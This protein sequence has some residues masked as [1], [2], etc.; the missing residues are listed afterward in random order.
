MKIG[1]FVAFGGQRSIQLRDDEGRK[2]LQKYVDNENTARMREQVAFINDVLAKGK[3][4]LEITRDE[5]ETL[6][7]WMHQRS[8]ERNE[9]DG[10]LRLQDVSL[11]RVFN[12]T[13][14]AT[15][16]RFYGG[17]WQ[18]IPSEYRTRIRINEK[19][20]VELDFGTLHPTMLY[21]EVGLKPPEDS[22]QI[23]LYPRSFSGA[24]SMA[25]YRKLVKRCFNAMLNASHRLSRPPRDVDLSAWGLKWD[26][27][28]DAIL[29]RHEPIADQFFTGRGLLLQRE[30]SDIAANL[31]EDF[32]RRM[33]LVPLLPVH[34]SFI[35]HHGY[36]SD[37]YDAMKSEF[38]KRYGTSVSVNVKRWEDDPKHIAFQSCQLSVFEDLDLLALME[39]F[40]S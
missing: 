11:Y 38:K 10:R 4:D 39:G 33:G 32:A 21:S 40:S 13:D 18:V 24:N 17:W 20:T 22:Y 15:G 23:G 25:A 1:Q 27:M 34:D 16:G 19:R 26:Q 14:F 29:D 31:M 2:Y 3:F 12:D 28:V 5:L 30:D 35:C 37:V 8:Q 36:E 6:E 7:D 9:G